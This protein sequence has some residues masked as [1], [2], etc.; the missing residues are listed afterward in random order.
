HMV[1]T[2]RFLLSSQELLSFKGYSKMYDKKE[3][4]DRDMDCSASLLMNFSGDVQGKVSCSFEM[5]YSTSLEVMGTKGF[6]RTRNFVFVEKDSEI[7][8]FTEESFDKTEKTLEINNGNFYAAE[9]MHF[10]R[11]V[12]SDHNFSCPGLDDGLLNQ[13]ILN[14]WNDG[15]KNK[16]E[17]DSLMK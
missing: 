3:Y 7:C 2:I 11:C 6:I 1:D 15:L 13:I 14:K 9:I 8:V 12:A 10:A 17:I 5:P 4:P 16:E